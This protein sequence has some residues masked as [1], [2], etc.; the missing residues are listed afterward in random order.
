MTP[1]SFFDAQYPEYA[2]LL[3]GGGLSINSLS[4]TEQV[5][6]YVYR[7]SRVVFDTGEIGIDSLSHYEQRFT[8]AVDGPRPRVYFV[9][10]VWKNAYPIRTTTRVGVA[11][12]RVS[13]FLLQLPIS[14][15]TIPYQALIR[16]SRA[17][18]SKRLQEPR[19]RTVRVSAPLRPNPEIVLTPKKRVVENQ[20][21][22]G[23]PTITLGTRPLVTRTWT[24]V[25]T[26]NFKKLRPSQY[27]VNNHAVRIDI[28]DTNGPN[29]EWNQS[30]LDGSWNYIV[31]VY[32]NR[33]A[34][35]GD[36]SHSGESYNKALQRLIQA[37]GADIEAN[38]A[39]DFAQIGQTTRLVATTATKIAGSVL[40][41]KKGNISLAANRLFA[42]RKPLYRGK[43][44]TVTNSL[45]QNWL[46]LQY[47][48]KPLLQDIH[49]AFNALSTFNEDESFVRRVVSSATK[50]F[51]TVENL[52]VGSTL[53]TS[54]G[55]HKRITRTRTKTKFVMRYKIEDPLKSFLA[56]TGFTNP[57][58]LAWEILPFSF[59]VDWFLPIGPYLETLSS[60]D[61]LTFLDGVQTQF[62]RQEVAAVISYN[63][64]SLLN[65][66]LHQHG[67]G[68]FHREIILLERQKL[69]SFPRAMFPSLKNGLASVTHALNG[70]AL[71][72]SAFK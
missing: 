52:G 59:V 68:A 39:Q 50:E 56:Q 22:G 23:I 14:G 46:E 9:Y 36:P 30:S 54:A 63:G 41:L 8:Y 18:T 19:S 2:A 45:A 13:T 21:S 5:R 26:P 43:G 64:I 61:G 55:T 6:V 28:T 33:Y 40:A 7:G 16:K 49:G 38:L 24:G 62:T 70:L 10:T 66:T 32:T 71:L 1:S 31:D 69:F 65:P 53:P 25:R 27:P 57:V 48:W 15:K 58:N 60:W 20:G 17:L 3:S 29:V 12:V 72:R 11:G 42:G 44:P 67:Y 35:P 51:E 34:V 47:G 37:A 4:A